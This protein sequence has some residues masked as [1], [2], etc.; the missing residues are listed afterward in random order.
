[1]AQLRPKWINP[2]A[3]LHQ[4]SRLPQPSVRKYGDGVR[5]NGNASEQE[6]FDQFKEK[7]GKTPASKEELRTWLTSQRIIT[8]PASVAV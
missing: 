8:T 2:Y 6:A 1:M 5:V 4:L 3:Q 7:T